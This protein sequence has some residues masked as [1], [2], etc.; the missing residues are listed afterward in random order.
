M[1]MYLCPFIETLNGRRSRGRGGAEV[2]LML[3]RPLIFRGPLTVGRAP[4]IQRGLMIR[5]PLMI[6]VAPDDQR[7]P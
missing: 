3:R 1:Y 2:P 4:E 6:R 7:G 5:G